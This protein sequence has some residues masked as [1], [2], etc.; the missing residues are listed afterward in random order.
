MKKN[1]L[2]LVMIAIVCALAS[3]LLRQGGEKKEWIALR[4]DITDA[5]DRF[6]GTQGNQVELLPAEQGVTA[7][8]KVVL[9]AGNVSPRQQQW[10]FP[11]LRFVAQRNG[12]PQLRGLAINELTN[13]RAILE[14]AEFAAPSA[15]PR[16]PYARGNISNEAHLQLMQRQAQSWLDGVLGTG[17]GLALVDGSS[18]DLPLSL[19][20]QGTENHYLMPRDRGA[21]RRAPRNP[22][23][24][25][26]EAAP[27][28][29]QE[30]Q[31]V[32][33]ATRTEYTT[34]LVVV[35][36]GRAEG[37]QA[38]LGQLPELNTLLQLKV[39]QRDSQRVVVLP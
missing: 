23:E 32:R 8:V 26:F 25:S 24:N 30:Q 15:A 20:V 16:E 18:Q 3:Q 9:P 34:I 11:L 5:L 13:Q 22:Q 6:W 31:Q 1:L 35:V 39:D 2:A 12:Q 27:R 21:S 17:N 38:K 19:P 14:S 33:Q 7:S 28:Q 36:N 10:N 4:R 29:S 37:V